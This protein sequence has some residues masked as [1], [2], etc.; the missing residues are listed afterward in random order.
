MRSDPHR[1]RIPS[2]ELFARYLSGECTPL[3][4]ERIETWASRDPS[5]ARMLKQMAR[6]WDE[7]AT[8]RGVRGAGA[9]WSDLSARLH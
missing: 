7:A 5:R 4:R 2:D 3:E 6:A 9:F 1:S 8:I